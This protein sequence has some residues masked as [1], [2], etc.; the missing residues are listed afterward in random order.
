MEDNF[1]IY[2]PFVQLAL[3]VCQC[4]SKIDTVKKEPIM[5]DMIKHLVKR[6]DSHGTAILDLWFILIFCWLFRGFSKVKS[7]YR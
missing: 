4:L 5:S 2:S 1:P 3:E 6:Y 7:Y